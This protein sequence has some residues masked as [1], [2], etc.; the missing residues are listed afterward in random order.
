MSRR[1]SRYMPALAAVLVLAL[2]SAAS[3]AVAANGDRDHRRSHG[4]WHSQ[5]HHGCSWKHVSGLDERWLTVHIETNLFEIAGG[6]AAESKATTPAVRE[7]AAELVRDHTA[8]LEQAQA[9]ATKVHVAIPD[10]PAPLQEWALRAVQQ[11]GGV[12][13]DRWFADLQ[14][15]GHRQAIV[16]AS[17]E[18]DRG[19]N[20]KVRGLAEASL[21]VLREHLEHAEAVLGDLSD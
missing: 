15:E 2:T 14:V 17:T 13:F 12:D 20:R 18:A 7:L 9:V 21:P 16:E 5:G 10:R 19:C 6:Q 3:F 11:F 4:G 1:L 8:A